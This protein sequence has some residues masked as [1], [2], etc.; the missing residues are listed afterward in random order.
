[1]LV[2]SLAGLVDSGVVRFLVGSARTTR[3][4]ISVARLFI[5]VNISNRISW[6]SKGGSVFDVASQLRLT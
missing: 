6:F 5:R 1:M 3:E 4:N 2:F